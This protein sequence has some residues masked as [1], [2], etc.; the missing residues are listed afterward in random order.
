[1]ARKLLYLC[2]KGAK[3]FRAP[4]SRPSGNSLPASIVCYKNRKKGAKGA[5]REKVIPFTHEKI[6]RF[7]IRNTFFFFCTCTSIS[8]FIAPFAPFL[9]KNKKKGNKIN[10][11]ARGA[12]QGRETVFAPFFHLFA[13][14]FRAL[15][16]FFNRFCFSIKENQRFFML[17][18]L[19]QTKRAR[20]SFRAL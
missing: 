3:S 19:T 2:L 16:G 8:Y 11:L 9:I 15:I 5:E 14:F 13:P 17:Q 18:I 1:M 4:V 7:I 10:K 20:S 6:T 12:K